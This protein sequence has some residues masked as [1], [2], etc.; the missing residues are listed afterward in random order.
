MA[1]TSEKQLFDILDSIQLRPAHG[2][3]L[4]SLSLRV[5]HDEVSVTFKA[6]ADSSFSPECEFDFNMAELLSKVSCMV[7]K[8]NFLIKSM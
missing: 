2:D 8:Q 4:H 6:S 3:F 5:S 1:A 7:R